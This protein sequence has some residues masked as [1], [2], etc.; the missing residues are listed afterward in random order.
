MTSS[1]A[2]VYFDAIIKACYNLCVVQ[3]LVRLTCGL[4]KK[5]RDSLVVRARL[6]VQLTRHM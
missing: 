2:Q 4:S 3:G 6:I 5:E 1:L